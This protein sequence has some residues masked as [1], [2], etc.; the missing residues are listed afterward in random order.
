MY[1]CLSL[2]NFCYKSNSFYNFKIKFNCLDDSG[3]FDSLGYVKM[4]LRTKILLYFI[5]PVFLLNLGA[6]IF[7]LSRELNLIKTQAENA[8][9][10]KTKLIADEFSASN[11]QGVTIATTAAKSVSNMGFGKRVDNVSLIRDLLTVHNSFIGASVS[12]EPNADAQDALS[13]KSLQNIKNGRPPS[14]DGAVDSYNFA[15]NKTS[16]D[17]NTWIEKSTGGRFVTYW[18]RKNGQ[19]LLEPLVGMDT[20]MYAAG[21]KKKI[22]S[23]SKEDYIITE[24]YLYGK[25]LMI[26]YSAPIMFGGIYSG[27]IAFDRSLGHTS[28]RLS[29]YKAY[30]G[31][32]FFLI[33]QYGK[34][35]SSTLDADVM[36]M[37]VDDLYIDD[38]GNFVKDFLKMKDGQLVRDKVLSL[39][40]DFTRYHSVYK[41]LIR[42]ILE[43]TDDSSILRKYQDPHTKTTYCI[44]Y[45][46]IN[47]GGWVIIQL[48]PENRIYAP[49]Y[50]SLIDETS[51]LIVFALGLIL[52]IFILERY[53]KKIF[54]VTAAAEQISH[55]D[56]RTPLDESYITNDEV[57][58]LIG[59]INSMAN[60]LRSLIV[61]V[62]HSSLQLITTSSGMENASLNYESKVHDFG[63]STSQIVSAVKSISATSVELY[64]MLSHLSTV[65]SNSSDTADSGRKHLAS[66]ESTMNSLSLNTQV[67][68]RSLSL[69]SQKANNINS[70]IT[71]ISKVADETNLLS[72][73]AAIEAEKAGVYGAG[74]AVVAREIGRLAEQTATAT[75][76]IEA[77][78]RDMQGS[79]NYGVEEM[80]KFSEEVRVGV[81]EVGRIILGMDSII[82]QMQEISPQLDSVTE[83]MQ[84][85]NEGASQII[86]A[87]VNL[88]ES[89]KQT[90]SLLYEF[91]VAREH[92]HTAILDL[93]DEISKFQVGK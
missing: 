46:K 81:V 50:A 36:T 65:A 79:V 87:M 70:V 14:E 93:R 77:I 58:M 4:K 86:S 90:E 25:E 29:R 61:R 43:D 62:R 53:S 6:N 42:T 64:R 45:A 71:A 49:I 75:S 28:E 22:E 18:A 19:L 44:A 88:N 40:T 78:V 84:S 47:P 24:P 48:I 80:K 89:A 38:K 33:S 13:L 63:N 2:T 15:I 41:D 10:L 16:T 32:E 67:I 34:V 54:K 35:V 60:S 92:L 21:L 12:Y 69:I 72:L 55:G 73:N 30:E 83:G 17:I 91:G 74:F 31:A 23:G 27:Q 68:A 82:T 5:L 85:Q 51:M 26:E 37:S 3:C 52:V 56:L 66:M 11:A 57:G 39:N 76:D 59:A 1:I 9:Y 8:L 7:T 20:S